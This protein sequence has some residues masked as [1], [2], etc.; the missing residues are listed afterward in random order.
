MRCF[1]VRFG[2]YNPSDWMQASLIDPIV[3]TWR[4]VMFAQ[5]KIVYQS[6]VSDDQKR[7]MLEDY[8]LGVANRF[9]TLCESQLAT[10]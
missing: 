5:I 3:E 8:A 4:E 9:H 7:K 10:R 6:K 2:Y 1:A